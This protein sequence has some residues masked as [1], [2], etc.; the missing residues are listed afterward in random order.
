MKKRIDVID[1]LRGFSLLGILIANMLYFQYGTITKEEIAPSTW[2]DQAA[3]YFTK[4]AVEAF[5]LATAL[6]Y[7]LAHWKN[8]SLVQ[9]DRFGVGR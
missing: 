1:S 4:I 6:F 7:L 2:W 9:E 5:Y 3:F 8:V